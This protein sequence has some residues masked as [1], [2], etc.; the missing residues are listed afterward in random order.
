VTRLRWYFLQDDWIARLT[1]RELQ[2]PKIQKLVVDSDSFL[3][4]S[5][6]IIVTPDAQAATD[7]DSLIFPVESTPIRAYNRMHN[8][9]TDV[10]RAKAVLKAV[11]RHRQK[12]GFGLEQGGCQLATSESNARLRAKEEVFVVVPE[13]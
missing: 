7:V 12:V 4:D 1:G 5:H 2:T 13:G 8:I 3:K 11:Q 6:G 10:E 9:Q